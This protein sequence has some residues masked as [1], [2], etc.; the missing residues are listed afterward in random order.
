MQ[1]KHSVG[2]GLEL[3]INDEELNANI[4]I[5][6]CNNANVIVN[7]LNKNNTLYAI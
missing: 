3:Y 5:I 7:K 1:G 2:I 4:D 6:S